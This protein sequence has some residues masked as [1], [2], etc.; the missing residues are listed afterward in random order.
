MLNGNAYVFVLNLKPQP[1]EDAHVHVG[2]PDESE[3]CDEVTAPAREDELEVK[4]P[5]CKRRDVVREAVFAGEE[6][7]EFTLRQRFAVL[8]LAFAELAWL[9]KDF[10]M[11]NCPGGAGHR[12]GEKQEDAHLVQQ[13]DV[14]QICHR[15]AQCGEILDAR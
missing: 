10:F 1:I 9:A 13:R 14:Q 15:R 8:A 5:E 2:D 11:R 12:H 7:E 4:Y 6:I 3:P